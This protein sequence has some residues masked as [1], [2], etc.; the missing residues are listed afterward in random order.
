MHRGV[1]AT[2]DDYH[3][4]VAHRRCGWQANNGCGSDSDGGHGWHGR[5][6]QEAG[7]DAH[8]RHGQFRQL[9]RAAGI[10]HLSHSY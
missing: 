10:Q 3:L 7:A 9:L 2:E 8:R 5:N 6:A 4:I 1:L